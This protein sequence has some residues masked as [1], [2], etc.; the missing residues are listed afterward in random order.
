[1]ALR[2]ETFRIT[3]VEELS[4][5]VA[6]ALSSAAKLPEET[7]VVLALH[8]D[9]GAGKTTF[10]QMLAKALG[11]TEAVTSP[12]FVIMKGY[13][14]HEQAFAHLVHIDAY[15]LETSQELSIL[16]FEHI[17]RESRTLV[18]IEWA[19]KVADLLPI[20]TIN[21]TFTIDGDARVISLA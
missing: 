1:M 13:E 3:V 9:L 20:H 11:V 4:G 21:L 16:H 15:R 18:V 14:L 10:T 19:A 12:T 2:M 7:A 17:L 6:A 8:G 5:V